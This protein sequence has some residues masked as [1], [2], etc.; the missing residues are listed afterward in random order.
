MA[1]NEDVSKNIKEIR[2]KKNITQ[3]EL[4]DILGVT[5]RTIQNYESGNRE[6]KIGALE[7]LAKALNVPLSDL[8]SE[9]RSHEK[10]NVSANKKHYYSMKEKD[11]KT[12]LRDCDIDLDIILNSDKK[13]QFLNDLQTINP[14]KLEL[15]S[16]LKHFDNFKKEDLINFYNNFLDYLESYLTT[17]IE[18]EYNPKIEEL[19]KLILDLK[20]LLDNRNEIIKNQEEIIKLQKEQLDNITSILNIQKR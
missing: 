14:L 17:F 13:N 4:A 2:N 6:P 1:I 5:V 20:S 7:E 19:K 8:L 10:I 11:L 12:F 15:N 3:K 18:S 16:Y 9:Y